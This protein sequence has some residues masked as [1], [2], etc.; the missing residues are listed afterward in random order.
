MDG[1]SAF[2]FPQAVGAGGFEST[3]LPADVV[4][5]LSPS[6][7]QAPDAYKAAGGA[8]EAAVCRVCS[9]SLLPTQ[10]CWRRQHPWHCS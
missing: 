5:G 7:A 2:G 8:P 6:S 1:A 10:C 9:T 3:G 4:A